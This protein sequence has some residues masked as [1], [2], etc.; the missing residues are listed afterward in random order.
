MDFHTRDRKGAIMNFKT[1]EEAYLEYKQNTSI[2]KIFWD[3]NNRWYPKRKENRWNSI[4]EEKIEYLSTDYAS[5]MNNSEDIFWVNQILVAPTFQNI[6]DD[7]SLNDEEKESKHDVDCIIRC[8]TT[9]QF[10]RFIRDFQYIGN[11]HKDQPVDL[12]EPIHDD[13]PVDL[14]E[15]IHDDYPVDLIEPIHDDYPIALLDTTHLIQR[16]QPNY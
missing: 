8:L 5:A 10:E 3:S 7:D 13:Q 15:P 2:W 9:N 6:I 14:I 1:L 11:E 12:I 16:D 4:Y